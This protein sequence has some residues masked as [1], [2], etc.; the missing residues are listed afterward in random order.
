MGLFQDQLIVNL[1][2]D[3]QVPDGANAN[4]GGLQAEIVHHGVKLEDQLRAHRRNQEAEGHGVTVCGIFSAVS[5]RRP[6][7]PPM[8]KAVPPAKGSN[9]F[10]LFGT[11]P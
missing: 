9:T 2:V 10:S 8:T 1:L 7:E 11:G 5:P 4:P 3:L 6:T